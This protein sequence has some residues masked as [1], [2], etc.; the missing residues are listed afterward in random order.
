MRPFFESSQ[1]QVI[2]AAT[3]G[4]IWGRKSTVLEAEPSLPVA[5]RR[6]SDATSRPSVTGTKLKK[7][8]SL[9]ALTIV[10]NRFGSV[11]VL[12]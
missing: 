6:I 9:K 7:K 11:T 2:P 10:T 5:T 1:L 4:M 12:T 3:S 8:I